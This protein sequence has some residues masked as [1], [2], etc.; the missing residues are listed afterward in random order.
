M[1]NK[2]PTDHRGLPAKVL[3]KGQGVPVS[4]MCCRYSYRFRP[5]VILECN[6]CAGTNR[7]AIPLAEVIN[8]RSRAHFKL[9]Q[10]QKG[11]GQ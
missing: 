2:R 4:V 1:S 11:E 8:C 7:R 3:E 5:K 10:I 9:H 6:N